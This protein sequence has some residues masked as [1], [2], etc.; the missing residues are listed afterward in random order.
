[1]HE[2]LDLTEKLK[3][4]IKGNLQSLMNHLGR[5]WY[6]IKKLQLKQSDRVIDFGC[7]KGYG[8]YL[9]SLYSFAIG[10]EINPQYREE[11]RK[12]FGEY[13]YD[14]DI[15]ETIGCYDYY[16]KAVCIEVIEHVTQDKQRDIIKQIASWLKPGGDL[17]LTFPLGEDKP[18]AYNKFHVCEPSIES[19]GVMMLDNHFDFGYDKNEIVNTFG[20]R[21]IQV[22]M[23]GRK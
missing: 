17:F 1:M 12:L 21:A 10:T 20:K 4:P 8:T 18:S 22:I 16:D 19:I 15:L 13:F 2:T 5:Y 23:W 6:A 7:G 14:P 9:I 11:A 3:D